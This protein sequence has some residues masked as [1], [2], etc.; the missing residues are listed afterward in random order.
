MSAAWPISESCHV[1]SNFNPNFTNTTTPTFL[2][3]APPHPVFSLPRRKLTRPAFALAQLPLCS[4]DHYS[5]WGISSF[6]TPSA[7]S[8]FVRSQV[9][10]DSLL[11]IPGTAQT[12][13]SGGFAAGDVQNTQRF[14]QAATISKRKSSRVLMHRLT[15]PKIGLHIWNTYYTVKTEATALILSRA[16]R[17]GLG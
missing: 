17:I 9:Q 14:R 5:R 12:N 4:Q 6:S 2:P 15:K 3:P 8:P 11:T 7:M 16:P 13:V 10:I 1:Y